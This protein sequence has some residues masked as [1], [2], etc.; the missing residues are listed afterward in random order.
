MKNLKKLSGILLAIAVLLACTVTAFA[1][2]GNIGS[3]TVDNP[4]NGQDYTAYKIFDV[5]Y[6]DG[7]SATYAYTIASDSKWY[8]LVSTYATEANGLKLTPSAIG[9]V[10]N[11][12]YNVTFTN[13]GEHTFSAAAFAQYLQGK[14]IPSEETGTTLNDN[15]DGTVSA[16]GLALGYYYVKST[17]GTI[18]NL[19]TTNP[20]VTIHDKNDFKFTKSDGG[21]ESVK[22]GD[23]VTYT[24]TGKV[25]DTTGYSTYK[26]EINDTMT[27]GL[28]FSGINSINVTVGGEPLTSNITKTETTHG[29]KLEITV[30]NLQDKVGKDIVVTYTAKVND[31][32]VA[33]VSYNQATL[34]YHNDPTST[35]PITTPQQIQT[36][37]SAQIEINKVDSNNGSA[38]ANATFVLKNASNQYYRYADNVVSWVG[39]VADA[40]KK[41][42]GA[43][44]KATFDGLND[45]TYYLV[46]TAAPDGYN[47]LEE[48]KTVTVD[49]TKAADGITSVTLKYD[50][51]ETTV[52]GAL[53]DTVRVENSTGSILPST[54]GIGTTIFYIV[55]GVLVAAA[56]VL[57]VAKKRTSEN[58]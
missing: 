9:G 51:D 42:T 5:S 29:F 19:T 18:A 1:E 37:Y 35:E 49:G 52:K 45:G 13:S 34:T 7:G 53:I 15:G 25:P 3:I 41:T 11:T 50:S 48:E 20:T 14:A 6:T 17:S 12:I 47:L 44:G 33:K 26:Y 31:K 40:T 56:V 38:L 24:I 39:N 30:K 46:E 32:A 8:P 28:T 57:L 23:T 22:V 21:T 54:G 36:V 58:R 4:I 43:D 55:G 27:E 10:T 2:R 16:T